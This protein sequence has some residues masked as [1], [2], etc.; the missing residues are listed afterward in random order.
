ML[1]QKAMTAVAHPCLSHFQTALQDV[2]VDPEA[3]GQLIMLHIQT[4]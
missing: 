2:T 3:T 1:I 4:H